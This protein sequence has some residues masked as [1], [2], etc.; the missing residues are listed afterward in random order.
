MPTGPA[1]T[2]TMGSCQSARGLSWA[3]VCSIMAVTSVEIASAHSAW[4][5]DDQRLPEG[6]VAALRPDAWACAADLVVHALHVVGQAMF[7]DGPGAK[8]RCQRRFCGAVRLGYAGLGQN[9]ATHSIAQDR[10]VCLGFING[11]ANSFVAYHVAATRYDHVRTERA[12]VCQRGRPVQ[13]VGVTAVGG[14]AGLDEITGEQHALLWQ[15]DSRIAF[16]VSAAQPAQ[17]HLAV[18]KI[19]DHGVVE[20]NIGMC[21]ARH[22]RDVVEETREAARLR[23]EVLLT[24]LA[25]QVACI[26]VCDDMLGPQARC[27]GRAQH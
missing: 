1:P 12:H 6:G 7:E 19:K 26:A 15:P 20:T 5:L 16:C 23:L 8:A 22:G 9:G 14:G 11:L 27:G 21:Q 24:T 18:S 4:C 25:D 2:I 13:D 10:Q 17:L 3:N